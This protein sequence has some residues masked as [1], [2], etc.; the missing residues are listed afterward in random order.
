MIIY[1]GRIPEKI[2]VLLT[3]ETLKQVSK[4]EKCSISDIQDM[5]ITA[6]KGIGRIYSRAL[7]TMGI[8]TIRELAVHDMDPE[9]RLSR[10][11]T[12]KFTITAKIILKWSQGQ[13]LGEKKIVLAGLDNAGKTSIMRSLK[14]FADTESV[15]TI[16]AVLDHLSFAGIPIVLWDF[17]G[18]K[19]FRRMYLKT[20]RYFQ[21][22]SLLFYVIDVRD[23]RTDESLQYFDKILRLVSQLGETPLLFINLHKMDPEIQERED[24]QRRAAEIESKMK[25]IINKQEVDFKA[26][27][28]QSSVYNRNYLLKEFSKAIK[29]LSPVSFILDEILKEICSELNSVNISVFSNLGF[30]IASY[31]KENVDK[32]VLKEYRKIILQGIVKMDSES[33]DYFEKPVSANYTCFIKAFMLKEKAFCVFLA[34][35]QVNF[36][37]VEKIAIDMRIWLTNLLTNV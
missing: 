6:I 9:G 1:N 12:R 8:T 17:G 31:T 37:T 7:K 21:N 10:Y 20:G 14:R 34:P 36:E 26:L 28:F 27:F 4:L 13:R 19:S 18:Q 29:E 23:P 32:S 15:P 33:I 3:K 16:G 22:I 30:Q 25:D 5:N 35:E 11:L 24:L 2:A